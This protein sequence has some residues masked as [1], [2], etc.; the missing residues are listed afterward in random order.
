MFEDPNLQTIAAL[1]MA[2]VLQLAGVAIAVMADPY[3]Q[4]ANRYRVYAI[5]LIVGFLLWEPQFSMEYGDVLYRNAPI[6]W[7][8]LISALGYILRTVVLYLFV[9]LVGN[10]KGTKLLHALIVVNAAF[11]MSS[12]F[13]HLVFFYDPNLHWHRGPLG[14]IP[15]GVSFV[16]VVWIVVSALMKYRGIR[17]REAVVPIIISVMVV[18][19]V[20]LDMEAYFNARVTFLTV[21]MTESIVFFYIWLHLQFV[22][23][24]ENALKAEQRIRIMMSQ[25]QPHFLF[26]TLSTI[27]ALTEIDPER[28]SKVIEEFALYLRQN[29]NSLN[30]EDMISVTKELEHT[31][32]YS[33]IEQVRFP[34]IKIEYEIEDDDFLIPPLTIQPM[35]E[36]AIRHGVRGKKHGWVAVSTWREEDAHVISI[37]DNGK[38][39]DVDK[40]IE[41]T[42]KGDHIGLK[43][44][45]DRII[46]MAG[47]TF[48][49][50]SVEGEGTS[51]TIK[52]PI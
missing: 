49:I 17:R 20:V 52:I 10:E 24:H 29:I 35:V 3:I 19:A 8:T 32:I 46:D 16:M 22:R 1:N 48:K 42:L 18:I 27:Q 15:F 37:R 11:C 12:F 30:E 44:V 13:S 6:F 45:R 34:S 2:L 4:K 7:Y 23:E 33:D 39:F 41:D 47:G 26:N 14:Y 5:A 21:A 43:N 51:V 38:G 31:R 36:N 25:I 40:M 50:E 9:R 28:A